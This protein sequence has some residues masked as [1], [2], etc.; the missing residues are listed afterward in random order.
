MI[1]NEE[2]FIIDDGVPAPKNKFPVLAQLGVLAFIMVGI[3]GTLYFQSLKNSQ[4]VTEP[5]LEFG[6]Q[7][8]AQP[9]VPQKI[10]NV[11]LVAKSAYV[12]DVKG[13]RVLFSKNPDAE[14]PLASITKLMTALLTFELIEQNEK[15]SIS[16]SAIKQE[17]SSGLSAG[18]KMGIEELTELALVSSSND[19][20]YAL[21]ANV[22]QLLGDKDPTSQFI[23][24][25]NIRAEELNLNTL[26]FKNMTG[27]DLS[28][29]EP[30]A[31]GSARDISFL[32]EYIITNYPEILAPT[33]QSGARIYNTA[34][35]Y[36]EVSNTNEIALEIPNLLGSK[37]GYTDLAG[38]NLTIAFDVG[39]DRPII[40][41]VLG[42]TRDERFTDVLKL[43]AEVQ[44]SFS[45]TI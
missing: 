3:F 31:V 21:A 29:S 12:W 35:A 26:H 16:M 6:K 32:M 11:S 5:E 33:K 1:E 28:L 4:L 24:A 40:I 45:Q 44:K 7:N 25:M 23:T 18:E 19:A 14:L 10:E 41:T 42:S 39:M 30:G 43:V 13:Q 27:L 9:V 20:A 38:G 17:G 36:H 22:G 37:T 34:G 2:T 15:A 8:V